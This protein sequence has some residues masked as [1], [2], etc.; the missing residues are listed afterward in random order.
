MLRRS[1]ALVLPALLASALIPTV[2]SAAPPSASPVGTTTLSSAAAD[3]F[4]DFESTNPDV[5]PVSEI[6]MPAPEVRHDVA[7]P[8]RAGTLSFGGVASFD[9]SGSTV[10]RLDGGSSS[11]SNFFARAGGRGSYMLTDRLDVGGTLGVL[12]R[13]APGGSSQ[14]ALFLE[15][16][17]GYLL[18]VVPRA[19]F[20]PRLGLGFFRGS[21]DRELVVGGNAA[22]ESTSVNGLTGTIYLMGAFQASPSVQVRSGLALTALAGWE[23]VGSVDRTLSS[24]ALFVGIPIEIDWVR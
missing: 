23:S 12:W 5:E 18:P 6:A 2:A 24:T 9:Y 14:K 22:T 4:A 17:V 1:P 15:A 21:A 8:T 16:T 3:P 7:I 19:A 10:E 13:D 11:N 20:A